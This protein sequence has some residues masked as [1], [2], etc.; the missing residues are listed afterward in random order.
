MTDTWDL[1]DQL[2]DTYDQVIPFFAHFGTA[3][4]DHVNPTPGARLLDIGTGRGAIATAAAARGCHVTAIDP[5]PRMIKHLDANSPRI[6][7]HV[8]DAHRLDFPDASFDLAT[9]G[10]VIHIVDDPAQVLAELRRVVRP[11]GTVAFTVPGDCDDHGRWDGF[12]TVVREFRARATDRGR[13]GKDI[14][15]EELVAAAGFI[16]IREAEHEVH[17]PID[18]PET[19]WRF[20]MSHGFAGF[21]ASLST[22]DAAAFKARALVELG[23][24]QKTGGIIVDRGAWIT[25][26][27]VA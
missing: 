5:S 3:L 17:I 11:G 14:D 9:A 12:N 20:Q 18:D 24:M 27:T 26:A 16:N 1:F 21:V 25:L 7:A 13:P 4:M 8:M 2:A 15:V 22:D 19:C 23:L 10:F 6:S